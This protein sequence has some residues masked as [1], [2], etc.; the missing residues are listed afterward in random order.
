MSQIFR[1]HLTLLSL[2]LLA[3]TAVPSGA[4]TAQPETLISPPARGLLLA[5]NIP[6]E[7]K[8]NPKTKRNDVPM[9]DSKS[10]LTPPAPNQLDQKK[11]NPKTNF[12]AVNDPK[13]G[14]VKVTPEA[15]AGYLALPP[16]VRNQLGDPKGGA[17]VSGAALQQLAARLRGFKPPNVPAGVPCGPPGTI[18]SDFVSDGKGG[19]TFPPGLVIW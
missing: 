9:T 10:K 18:G 16:S 12:V 7:D 19:C 15:R 6:P 1:S 13:W 4:T 5:Q 2:G 8:T 14:V 17:Q 11:L 3:T